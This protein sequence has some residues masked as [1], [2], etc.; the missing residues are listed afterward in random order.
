MGF[1]QLYPDAETHSRL[2]TSEWTMLANE[3]RFVLKAQPYASRVFR[4]VIPRRLKRFVLEPE[5]V[6]I[7]LRE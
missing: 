6:E 3:A 7:R 5:G 2:A 4:V 1:D